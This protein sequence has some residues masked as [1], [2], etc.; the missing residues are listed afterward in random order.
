[1]QRKTPSRS[2]EVCCSGDAVTTLA[3]IDVD[4]MVAAV[5]RVPASE[6]KPPQL[7]LL[8]GQAAAAPL[9]LIIAVQSDAAAIVGLTGLKF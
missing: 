1:M 8:V 2:W 3:E 6:V 7:H 4:G 5:L 9:C